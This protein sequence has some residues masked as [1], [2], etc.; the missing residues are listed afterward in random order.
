[1]NCE[2]VKNN[3]TLYLYNELG[4]D[5]RHE[6]EMH[7]NRCP[8]CAAEL[9]ALR[10]FHSSLSALPVAEPSPNMLTSS[11]MR[12]QEALEGV[13]QSRRWKWTLD[14]AGWLHQ[15]RFSPALAAV[16]LIMGFAGGALTTFA[17]KGKIP[18]PGNTTSI[19]QA[20]IDQAGI[21]AIRGIEQ[22][23][24]NANNV[25]I[26][27]DRLV[28]DQAQGSIDDPKIQRL[29]LYAARSNY[30][31]GVRMDSIDALTKK[32]EDQKIREM[33]IFALRYDKNPGVRLKAMEALGNYVKEDVRVRDAVLEALMRDSNPGVRTEAIRA[34]QPVTADGSVR[35]ALQLLAVGDNN[36]FI[37]SES[38]RLLASLPE[39]Q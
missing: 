27:F 39:I 38:K 6:L 13:E 16:L 35:Q 30:S 10:A 37:K 20:S 34:L 12:L 7:L 11:R 8:D 32:P 15:V 31:S 14:I 28:P 17:T 18:L 4:D 9:D 23:P 29:L 3:A 1:M 2:W 24:T 36:K 33:L 19:S 21:A 5:E 25:A 26:K 22:D